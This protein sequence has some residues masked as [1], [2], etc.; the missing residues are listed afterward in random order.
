MMESQELKRF[1]S[2][3]FNDPETRAEFLK[4]P[5][6]VISRF[7]LTKQ[8][9]RSVLNSHARLNMALTGSQQ[10]AEN[11]DPTAMWC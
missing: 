11:I 9:K 7:S 3:I 5:D 8:E 2:T 4:D 6:T 10:S 1:V